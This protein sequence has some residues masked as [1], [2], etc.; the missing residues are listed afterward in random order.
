MIAGCTV[1]AAG[2]TPNDL[3]DDCPATNA[4][5][6]PNKANSTIVTTSPMT[7]LRDRTCA[8]NSRRATNRTAWRAESGPRAESGSRGVDGS[9]AGSL[10]PP[11]RP[12]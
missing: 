4:P 12:R 5:I 1:A 3:C 6:S 10:T 2:V 7:K 9:L 11:P 8:T